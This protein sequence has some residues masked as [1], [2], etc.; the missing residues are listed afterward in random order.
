MGEARI[1]RTKKGVGMKCK[2]RRRKKDPA[3]ARM[4]VLCMLSSR[5]LSAT[6]RSLVQR[7]SPTDCG[8]SLSVI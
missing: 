2:Y 8:V 7:E 3:G 4:I 6:G 5:G 1:T